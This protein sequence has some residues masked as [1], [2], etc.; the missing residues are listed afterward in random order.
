MGIL[1]D[2]MVNRSEQEGKKR[3]RSVIQQAQLILNE[4]PVENEPA[5]GV[6][7][8]LIEQREEAGVHI[9]IKR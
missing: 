9:I 7:I 2:M 8:S 6:G 1:Y 4:K 3:I 5:S